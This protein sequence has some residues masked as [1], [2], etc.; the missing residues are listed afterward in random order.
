MKN[1][2]VRLYELAKMVDFT[3]IVADIGTDHGYIPYLLL[4][5][6]KCMIAIA[7]DIS[8]PS[9]KKGK[10]LLESEF[11]PFQYDCR[12]GDG[13]E[14]LEPMEANA[15]II[16]GMGGILISEV[17]EKSKEKAM[18]MDYLILQPMQAEEELM[19]YLTKEDYQLMEVRLVKENKK[20][21]PIFKMKPGISEEIISWESFKEDP[22]FTELCQHKI[23]VFEEIEE[24][25][26]K[27]SADKKGIEEIQQEKRKWEGYLV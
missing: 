10:S 9:L 5:E 7:T 19:D 25:I 15:V 8:E 26:Q 4:K 14:V 6:N 17:L 18:S 12:V 13:L 21:Y 23:H 16:A 2:S 24:Q 11:T 20:I 22:L 1:I 3:P 27:N